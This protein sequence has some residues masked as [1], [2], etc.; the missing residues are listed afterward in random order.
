MPLDSQSFPWENMSFMLLLCF[1]FYWLVMRPQQQEET[2]KKAMINELKVGDEVS[3]T[4]GIL[5]KVHNVTEDVIYLSTGQQQTLIIKKQAIEKKLEKGTLKR[6][7][8]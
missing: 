3:T 7:K 5:G 2:Q 1:G 4:S 8:K 6:Y